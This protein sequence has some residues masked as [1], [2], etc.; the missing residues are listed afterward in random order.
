[1]DICKAFNTQ[2]MRLQ[3]LYVQQVQA[4]ASV[5][6]LQAQI[7]AVNSQINTLNAANSLAQANLVAAMY[8]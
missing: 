5:P 4:Q 2:I 6:R 3:G 1:M 8:M 7:A